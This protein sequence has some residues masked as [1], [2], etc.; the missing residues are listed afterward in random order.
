MSE[1]ETLALGSINLRKLLGVP[2]VEDDSS[3]DMVATSAGSLL[4]MDSKVVAVI[5]PSIG[6]VNFF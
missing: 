1:E 4:S 5:S 2:Y 3:L 6:R